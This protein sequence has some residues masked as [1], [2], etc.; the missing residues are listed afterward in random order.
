[1]YNPMMYQQPQQIQNPE[2]A[3][4]S[5]LEQLEQMGFVNKDLNIQVLQQTQGNVNAAV[6]RLINM[7]G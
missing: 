1:M 4:K 3:F 6:E 2:D 5:Q 7:M